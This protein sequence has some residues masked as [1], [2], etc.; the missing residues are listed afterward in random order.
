[1]HCPLLGSSSVA[2]E[3]VHSIVPPGFGHS[4]ERSP[5]KLRPK[6]SG[7]TKH[8]SSLGGGRQKA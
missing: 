7:R 1:M 2:A 5:G 3:S 8:Q 6:T 4:G